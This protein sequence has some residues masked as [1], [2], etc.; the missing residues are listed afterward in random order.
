MAGWPDVFPDF[1][2]DHLAQDHCLESSYSPDRIESIK[3]VSE[4]EK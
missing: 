1:G 4:S 2:L 3:K